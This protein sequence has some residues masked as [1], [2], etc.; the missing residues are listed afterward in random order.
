MLAICHTK[1]EKFGDQEKQNKTKQ[2]KTKETT[3]LSWAAN[4]LPLAQ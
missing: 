2:N 1:I 3:Y 4:R